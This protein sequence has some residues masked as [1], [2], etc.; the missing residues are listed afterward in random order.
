MADVN[1]NNEE[2][3]ALIDFHAMTGCDY[4]LTFFRKVKPACWK[5]MIKKTRFTKGM[6]QLGDNID[7][8]EEIYDDF[9]VYI[10]TLYGSKGVTNINRLPHSKFKEKNEKEKKYVN[11]TTVLPCSSFYLYIKR[12]DRAAYMMKWATLSKVSEPP[13]KN[14]GWKND[15][16]IDWI[17]DPFPENIQ[18]I[19]PEN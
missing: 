17:A 13:L 19:L 16:G 10:C 11:L 9:E 3:Q 5:K 8:S 7:T 18:R 15:G 6:A 4:V 14:C 2:L 1:V 12:A